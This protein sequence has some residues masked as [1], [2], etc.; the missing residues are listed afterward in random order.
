MRLGQI[1]K[2]DDRYLRTLLVRGSRTLLNHSTRKKMR[3]A[4]GQPGQRSVAT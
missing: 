3:R 1:G 2:R 4:C